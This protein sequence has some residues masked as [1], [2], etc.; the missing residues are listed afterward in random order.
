M[1]MTVMATYIASEALFVPLLLERVDVLPANRLMTVCALGHEAL[2][3][4]FLAVG[5][6]VALVEALALCVGRQRPRRND[7]LAKRPL[8]RGAREAVRMPCCAE[9]RDARLRDNFH[10][11]TRAFSL[12]LSLNLLTSRMGL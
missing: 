7:R 6:A 9:C 8:T 3:K 4:A 1:T 5:S 11:K 12:S 2:D 10:V